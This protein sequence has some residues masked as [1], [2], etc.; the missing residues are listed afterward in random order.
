MKNIIVI[1]IKFVILTFVS[2]LIL[3]CGDG[4]EKLNSRI[5]SLEQKI[6]LAYK[7]GL[8][9]FM[10]YIQ[11]HHAKLWFAAENENW[12]LANFELGE[13]RETV[14]NIQKY[15]QYRKES[16]Q[17]AVLYPVLDSVLASINT[18]DKVQFNANYNTLTNTCNNCH[19]LVN[20]DF[21]KVKIPDSPP[22]S[23]QDFRPGK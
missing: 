9:E 1:I 21:N 16:Q 4:N 5:D 11:V 12:K 8:G 7:P 2:V 19:K 23:N 10:S 22:Y 15:V 14:S 18:Q 17:V 20:Y 13:L 3:S 6:S